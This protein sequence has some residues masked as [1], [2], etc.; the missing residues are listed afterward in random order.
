MLTFCLYVG[1][2][3][4]DRKSAFWRVCVTLNIG[5]V[6]RGSHLEAPHPPL[7]LLIVCM[8]V[9]R[10]VHTA[11]HHVQGEVLDAVWKLFN[12]FQD[13]MTLTPPPPRAAIQRS[14]RA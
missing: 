10:F 14:R 3:E 2:R 9:E 8:Q 11:M 6:L 7:N 5:T 13:F 1:W 4:T 12:W